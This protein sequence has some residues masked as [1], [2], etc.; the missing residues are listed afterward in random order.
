MGGYI[1]RRG[2]GSW[3]LTIDLGRDPATGQRKRRFLSVQGK[4]R[5]AERA[6][7]EALHQRDT[8]IDITPGKITVADYLRRWLRDYAEGAVAA[9]T[10]TRY[11]GIVEHHL[12]PALGWLKL[13]ELRQP[14]SR[15]PTPLLPVTIAEA[16]NSRPRPSL[17]TTPYC[18]NH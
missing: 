9:S 5:D 11:T 4:K 7:A 6:L 17:S 18:A 13:A 2:R 10:F 15:L 8:G 3:E 1:R 16:A 14:T 12:I